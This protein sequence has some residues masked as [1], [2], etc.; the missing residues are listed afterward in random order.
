MYSSGRRSVQQRAPRSPAGNKPSGAPTAGVFD[1]VRNKVLD[2]IDPVNQSE[3]RARSSLNASINTFETT[4][5]FH[6]RKLAELEKS[7]PALIERGDRVALANAQREWKASK[8][9]YERTLVR[10]EAA[11]RTENVMEDR[12]EDDNFAQSLAD[13]NRAM[14]LKDKHG[15]S[16]NEMSKII[17]DQDQ[18][19]ADQVERNAIFDGLYSEAAESYDGNSQYDIDEDTELQEMMRRVTDEFDVK[20]G[21]GFTVD[22]PSRQGTATGP[23]GGGWGGGSGSMPQMSTNERIPSAPTPVDWSKW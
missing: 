8:Q 6:Q 13:A 9:R 14:K 19:V 4:L 1:V 20:V 23:M 2:V 22:A 17:E 21:T 12:V 3:K 10:H 16:L 5:Q 7:M 15:I 18:V 11:L